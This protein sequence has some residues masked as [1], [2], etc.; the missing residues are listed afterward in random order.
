MKMRIRLICFALA[1]SVLTTLLPE[2]SSLANPASASAPS[3]PHDVEALIRS[4]HLQEAL[5]RTAPTSMVENIALARAVIAYENR[6]E[7]DDVGPLMQFAAEHPNSGWAAAV[8]TNMGYSNLHFGYYSRALDAWRRAWVSGKNATEPQAKALTDGAVGQ[9]VRLYAA[10]GKV[11]EVA[12]LFK[13]LGAR[14]ITGSATE[15]VQAA[16]EILTLSEKDPR[17]LYNCG[18][19]ALKALMTSLGATSEQVDFLQWYRARPG[20]TSL[21]EVGQLADK[22]KLPFKLVFRKQGEAI[23]RAAVVHWKVGHFAAIVGENAGRFHVIDP[24]FPGR[25]IWVTRAALDSEASGYYLVPSNAAVDEWRLVDNRE[26]SYIWGKGPTTGVNPG[27]AGDPPADD[28]GCDKG[29]CRYN[30][31]ESAVSL[32]LSDTP[33]GYS[34]TVGPSATTSLSYNQREDSQP[35]VFNFYNIGPKWTLNWLSYVTDD[36]TNPGANVSRYLAGGGAYYYTGYNSSTGQFAAQSVDGS[37]FVL[38]SQSPVRYR[39]LLSDGSTEIYSQSDGSTG[40]PR[41]I[42]LSQAIDAQGNNLTFTYDGQRRL[43]SLIDATGRQTSF[44]YD[45]QFWPFLVTRITDPFGRSAKLNYEQGRLVSITDTIGLTSSFTY[46]TNGLVN[47]MTTPYGV[48]N[49]AYT[50]PG[51]SGPPRFLQVTDPLGYN[52]RE[53]WLEPAPI[54]GSEAPSAVP[55]GMPG[56]PVNGY[57]EYRNSFHWD[58]NA[59]ISAGCTPAGGCDY[60]KA[61]VRH[62]SHVPNSSLKSTSIES[63]K[64]P[65][66]NRV[67]FSYPGQ[68]SSTYAGSFNKPIAIGR[69][70]DDG[71]TQLTQNSYDTSAFF[72]LTQT[73]DPVGRTTRFSYALNQ[74]DLLAVT[75]TTAN[76]GLTPIAQ[77]TYNDKHRPLAYTDAA[78]QTTVYAYNAA[79]QLASVT[80]PLKQTTSYQYDSV[81]N[82]TTITNANGA[83]AASFTYDAYARVRTY[84]DSEGWTATYDYDAADRVTKITYPDATTDIYVYDKLDLASF[85][86]REGRLWTYTHDANRR[87]TKIVDP[88]GN[89]TQLGYNGVNALTRLTDPKGN[90]TSWTYDVRGRLATKQYAD[91]STVSYGYETTTS[92]LKSVTDALGQIKQY[93]YAKDNRLT[94][95]S[96][97]NAVNLTPNVAFAYD[98]YFPRIASMTDGNGATHYSYV[99]GFSFGALRLQQECVVPTGAS[100][101]AYQIDYAYDGLGRRNS[102]TVSGSGAEMFQYDAIGRLTGHASDLGSFALSYLGQTGQITQRLLHNSTLSTS[103]SYLPNSGDRRLASIG[104]VGL[105]GSQFSNF[106]FTTTPENFISS[107]TETSDVAPV[108]PSSTNQL[109][110]YNNLNQLTNLSGQSLSYDANGNLLSDGSRTYSWDAENRLVAIAYPGQPGKATAFAYDGLGRRTTIASTP[111]GG[112]S[113]VATGYVWCGSQICQA[114]NASNSPTRGYYAEGEFVPGSPVLMYYYGLDQIGSVRRGFASV[115]SAPAFSYDPY[116]NALQ[117]TASVTDFAYAGLQNH[118]A[119]GLYLATFRA[120]DPVAGRWLSRDPIEEAGG[121]N[122]YA[123]IGG[124]PVNWV[125]IFGL[126]T[127]VVIWNGVGYGE[128]AFGHVSTNINGTNY[129]FGPGGWDTKYPMASDYSARQQT[130]RSGTGYNLALTP[131]QENG[132]GTC[133][134]SKDGNYNPIINNCGAAIQACLAELGVNIGNNVFPSS[135]GQSLAK[136]P[137]TL[138]TTIYRQ[139]GK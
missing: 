69:V 52:E 84:T 130:F 90:V 36:P 68:S 114:R 77:F 30:I 106:Q 31:K 135:I 12:G 82:L 83:T 11:D 50:A 111:E 128:S 5:V 51:T 64:E 7:P 4:V 127:Q 9:L 66:E 80:D 88:L 101:C 70:L 81:G 18:P 136:S 10:L 48:T 21:E 60:T 109:A 67:W 47:S 13:E 1:V 92:R 54:P 94:G 63:V 37:M 16:R 45:L 23:P 55:Q 104:N 14:P 44:N 116:G 100:T 73:I 98:A 86:D 79:G 19:T 117:S 61:R 32:T 134:K 72:N 97:S 112:G 133:L 102:R 6:S 119:S 46:D 34:P 138:D 93:A 110:S 74:I 28:G 125:D 95:V 131:N 62:F 129:S 126:D 42:F 139:V 2:S 107:I 38:E 132:L 120:Y 59:Y 99:G 33:V 85:Q 103:W 124:N 49:F 22:A 43:V 41:R 26:A 121:L 137:F 105:S 56:A 20:G 75:Q 118:P 58:K 39:R 96:Y 24:V 27:D 25:S 78:G 122:L 3:D 71:S 40:F 87:L 115:T 113:A 29:M 35:Q 123:Y 108:Y 76:S 17:H 57:L 53:E 8:L 91:S 15:A 65:L 89:E